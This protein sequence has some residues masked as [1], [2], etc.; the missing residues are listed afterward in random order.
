MFIVSPLDT[1]IAF[2]VAM[3]LMLGLHLWSPDINWG[4]ISQALIFHQVRKYL[5]LLD[6]RKEHVKY[7][8]PQML[9][10]VSDMVASDNLV[11]F[12]NDLKKGGKRPSLMSLPSLFNPTFI[13]K[14]LGI[15][16][17]K[18]EE[19]S[20]RDNT[21]WNLRFYCRALCYWTCD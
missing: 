15:N 21:S 20:R 6:I 14:K 17:E 16:P 2:I 1:A 5:L 7:W 4:S 19:T 9:L 11:D 13:K 8:R 12:V 18:S 3:L 10:L